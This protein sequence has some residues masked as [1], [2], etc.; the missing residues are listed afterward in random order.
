MDGSSN[1][2]DIAAHSCHRA[3][4][5]KP[6]QTSKPTQ[7]V[8]YLAGGFK[9]PPRQVNCVGWSLSM[10]QTQSTSVEWATARSRHRNEEQASGLHSSVELVYLS[11][12]NL[13]I[14]SQHVMPIVGQDAALTKGSQQMLLV[15]QFVWFRWKSRRVCTVCT[16]VR[17][18]FGL[19]ELRYFRALMI[20]NSCVQE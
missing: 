1:T 12:S 7:K 10:Q 18:P 17:K 16:P 4:K 14:T 15:S 8:K 19:S 2:A 20:I 9:Q 6:R 13:A 3:R 5:Q 11:A